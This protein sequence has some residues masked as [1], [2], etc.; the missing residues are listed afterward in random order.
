MKTLLFFAKRPQKFFTCVQ[1]KIGGLGA[2]EADFMFQDVVEGNNIQM[3]DRVV[4]LLKPKY[5]TMPITFK[6]MNRIEKLEVPEE[7][8]LEML[9]NAIIHKD[10]TGVHIQMRVWDDH[11][12]VWN[13]GELPVGYTPE[14]LLGLLVPVIRILRTLSLRQVLL[15]HG[16]VV[17]RKYVKGS[18]VLVCL[19]QRARISAEAFKS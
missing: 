13:D 7:A 17:T 14:T 1:F 19:C 5:L 9:Y 12:E 10:Y 6:G 3:T 8:L 4:E 2:D 16:D 18:R 15:M 11:V